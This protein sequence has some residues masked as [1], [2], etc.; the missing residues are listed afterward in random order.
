MPS[1]FKFS[2]LHP[3]FLLNILLKG[4]NLRK[5]V[6]LD[7]NPAVRRENDTND[8]KNELFL[9]N[10]VNMYQISRSDVCISRMTLYGL[11]QGTNNEY[12]I[13]II[14]IYICPGEKIDTYHTM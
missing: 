5:N 7:R 6:P 14:M 9:T 2:Q 4:I 11:L 12:H 8:T 13:G 10:C 3:I 1:V